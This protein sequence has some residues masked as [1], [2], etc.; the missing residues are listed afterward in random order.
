MDSPKLLAPSSLE[1]EDISK[2]ALIH[3]DAASNLA[4]PKGKQRQ[5]GDNPFDED[6]SFSSAELL[7]DGGTE[8]YPPAADENEES[9]RVQEVRRSFSLCWPPQSNADRVYTEPT[10]V[11]TQ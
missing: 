8:R 10:T 6:E 5:S 7:D 4:G 9:R 1:E 2:A 11:G 3:E